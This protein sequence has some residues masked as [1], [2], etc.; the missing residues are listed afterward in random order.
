[1]YGI[2]FEYSKA[3]DPT[4]GRQSWEWHVLVNQIPSCLP[5]QI[6]TKKLYSKTTQEGLLALKS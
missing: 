6:S 4:K 1:M 5:I 2:K 3:Q